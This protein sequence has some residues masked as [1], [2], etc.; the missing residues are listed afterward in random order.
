MDSEIVAKLFRISHLHDQQ[1][2]RHV[3]VADAGADR[4]RTMGDAR[5][6]LRSSSGTVNCPERNSSIIA[7]SCRAHA[8]QGTRPTPFRKSGKAMVGTGS[9]ILIRFG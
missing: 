6:P 8:A 1:A 3:R 2:H 7:L 5:W 4:C 9:D